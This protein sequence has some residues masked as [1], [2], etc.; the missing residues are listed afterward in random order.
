MIKKI[1]ILPGDGIGP[2]VI[3]EAAKVLDKLAT[4]GLKIEVDEGLIGGAAYDALG[5]PLP[6][7]T[8][9][10]AK[11]ADAILLGA[12]GGA[13]WETLPMTE[14]PERGL[15]GLRS[16]LNLFSNLIKI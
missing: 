12:V 4:E 1:L 9:D 6:K 2:E 7:L 13:K 3:N 5:T 15:L 11:S 10:M 16:E 14:R 8:L